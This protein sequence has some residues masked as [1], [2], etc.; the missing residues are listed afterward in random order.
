MDSEL[1]YKVQQASKNGCERIGECDEAPPSKG[2]RMN[3]TIEK[4]AHFDSNL[5][6]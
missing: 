6:I 2:R 1:L 3:T 4:C 5:D